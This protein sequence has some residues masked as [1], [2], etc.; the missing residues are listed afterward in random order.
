[1]VEFALILPVLLLIV[2]GLVETGRL[3][4][5]YSTV[6]NAARE[7]ARY[8]S[9]TGLSDN[10]I[11]RFMD[12]AEI[13]DAAVRVGFLGSVEPANVIV[14]YDNGP[15]TTSLGACPPSNAAVRTGTRIQVVVTSPFDTFIPGLLPYENLMIRGESARTIIRSVNIEPIGP[16]NTPTNTPTPSNTPTRTPTITLT[17]SDTP[18]PSNTPTITLTPIH[19]YTPSLTPTHTPTLTNTPTATPTFTN[20]PQCSIRA[21]S[22]VQSRT[23]GNSHFTLNFT[24][25][26]PPANYY[27][28]TLTITTTTTAGISIIR[29]NGFE[30]TTSGYTY[31]TNT[32]LN[33]FNRYIQLQNGSNALYIEYDKNIGI[34]H[35]TAVTLSVW[36]PAGLTPGCETVSWP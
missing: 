25:I 15:G 31:N 12:C 18:T 30:H 32:T 21:D 6:T 4:F 10:G 14:T 3:M 9:A 20:T 22:L 5:I 36:T 13:I 7:A 16:T 23:T 33:M 8:G 28:S 35:T 27:I 29:M 26:Q 2:L 34:D 17:P 19:S 1:M 11:P 24:L